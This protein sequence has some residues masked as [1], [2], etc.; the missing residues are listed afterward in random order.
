MINDIR[1]AVVT[2]G[3]HGIGRAICRRLHEEGATVVVADLDSDAAS[4]VAA[5]IDGRPMTIDV[6]EEGE[7]EALVDSVET[8]V[9]PID[10]FVSNAGVGYGDG[11]SGACTTQKT[12]SPGTSVKACTA[13]GEAPSSV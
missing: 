10:L 8:D 5:E 3:G 9:G 13:G 2:G 1:T 11:T 6:G 12:E 4:A 7:V